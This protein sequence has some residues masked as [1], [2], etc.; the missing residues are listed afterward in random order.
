MMSTLLRMRVAE[1][2]SSAGKTCTP[3]GKIGKAVIE[4]QAPPPAWRLSEG[5][6]STAF[7]GPPGAFPPQ[8]KASDVGVN[9]G[10]RPPTRC[11][12]ISAGPKAPRCRRRDKVFHG[13]SCSF[14]AV[15]T[16]QAA[17]AVVRPGGP[18]GW[19]LLLWVRTTLRALEVQA[20]H[21]AEAV[22]CFCAPAFCRYRRP[23]CEGPLLPPDEGDAGPSPGVWPH[24]PP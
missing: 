21:L 23:F 9:L 13:A 19:A 15:T 3:E 7:L 16:Y 4:T 6:L 24:E 10:G 8:S 17:A 22:V 1:F 12:P 18:G 11:V 20:E 14:G 5:P 2:P